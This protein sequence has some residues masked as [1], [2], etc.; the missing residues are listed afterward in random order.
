MESRNTN[1]SRAQRTLVLTGLAHALNDGFTDMIYVFLPVWQ[2]QFGLGYGALAELR[3]LNA[4]TVLVWGTLVSAAGCGLAGSSGGLVGL[5]A[6]L[7][8]AGAGGSTQHPLGSAAVSRAYGKRA[9]G[10]L[11]ID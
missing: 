9:R 2:S 11:G 6:S 5:C 4:R 8:L 7:T 3:A 1:E 10:P